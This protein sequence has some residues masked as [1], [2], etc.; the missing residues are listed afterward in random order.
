[1]GVSKAETFEGIAAITR[2]DTMVSLWQS[3]AGVAQVR[4]HG[5]RVE[6]LMASTKDGFLL[7]MVLLSSSAPPAGAARTEANAIAKRIAQETRL[8]V[9]L[10]VGGAVWAS[11]IRTVMR[12]TF[13]L[14]GQS[15]RLKVA[16]SEESALDLLMEK[17][18]PL[19]PARERLSA[20]I[21]ELYTA[22][23]IP[24]GGR[25]ARAAR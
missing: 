4:W 24:H 10:P 14:C 5:E 15:K 8:T 25:P 21:D 12:A 22:L 23:E 20:M 19:T 13:L 2:G 17:A 9:A 1:M 6:R 3:P 16:D 18:S 7:L 11:V